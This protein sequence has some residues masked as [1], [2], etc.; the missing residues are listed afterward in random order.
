MVIDVCKP[1][2][3]IRYPFKVTTICSPA[4]PATP[5]GAAVVL[6]LGSDY[7]D[8]TPTSVAVADVTLP[9]ATWAM[10]EMGPCAYPICRY[11]G[12]LGDFDP[13]STHDHRL[14]H[15]TSYIADRGETDKPDEGHFANV[16]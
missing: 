15:H 9:P 2:R 8:V 5:A 6:P 4:K 12:S 7:S 14:N 3:S 13:C 1:S 16:R 10:I 11:E